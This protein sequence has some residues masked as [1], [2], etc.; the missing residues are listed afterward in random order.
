VKLPTGHRY[1]SCLAAEQ[2]L[3]QLFNKD[4]LKQY[5]AYPP[6]GVLTMMER[7]WAEYV[8]AHP[9]IFEVHD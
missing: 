4:Q 8:D 9:R 1:A 7:L 6:H 5:H 3:K 2:A